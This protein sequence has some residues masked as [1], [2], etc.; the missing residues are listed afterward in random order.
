MSEVGYGKPPKQTR[1]RK[2]QSGNPGGRPKK[3]PS[4][5]E[6]LAAELAEEMTLREGAREITVT[7]QRAV[8]KALVQGALAGDPRSAKALTDLVRALTPN[9]PAE[10]ELDEALVEEFI[11]QE[12][13]SRKK[14]ED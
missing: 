2:G 3:Q 8:V 6:D 1:F 9:D 11:K 5:G 13:Q 7:K 10:T 14:Q 12:I 4:L